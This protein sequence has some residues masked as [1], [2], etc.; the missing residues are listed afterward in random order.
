MMKKWYVEYIAYGKE[1]N[2]M[3]LGDNIRARRGIVGM[4]QTMLAGA[5]G[6][7]LGAINQFE[8]SIRIPNAYTFAAIAKA[9][10]VTMDELM[11]GIGEVTCD[12]TKNSD[13]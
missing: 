7:T 11:Y 8:S 1:D 5:A 9:L 13:R 12:G 6:V 3:S 4:T 10:G 2:R